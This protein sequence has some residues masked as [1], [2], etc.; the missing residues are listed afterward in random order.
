MDYQIL[1]SIYEVDESKKEMEEKEIAF[2]KPWGRGRAPKNQ[3]HWDLKS[4]LVSEMTL[5][6]RWNLES[7]HIERDLLVGIRPYHPKDEYY[8]GQC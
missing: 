1:V 7:F 4:N 5:S 3:V 8:G 6:I 2:P